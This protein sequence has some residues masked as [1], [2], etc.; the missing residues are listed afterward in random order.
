MTMQPRTLARFATTGIAVVALLVSSAVAMATTRG[1]TT[2]GA[3]HVESS[4]TIPHANASDPLVTAEA[5]NGVV[6]VAVPRNTMTDDIEIAAGAHQP[7][8]FAIVPSGT[9]AM[10]FSKTDL[11]VAGRHAMSSFSRATGAVIRT[12]EVRVAKTEGAALGYGDGRLWALG[13]NG[14]GRHVFEIKPG[15]AGQTVVGSGHNV[16]SIA[17]G[18]RGVYF[19]R[20]G[21]HRLVRVAAD[22]TH[23]TAPTHETVN[24]ELSGPAAVQATAVDGGTLLVVHDAGQGFDAV[25]VRYNAKSLKH[26]SSAPTDDTHADAVPTTAGDLVL[27]A[28]EDSFG[29]SNA[30]AKACVARISTK[31]AKVSSKVRLPRGVAL[32]G[33]VGPDPAVVIG[34]HG[35][36]HLIRLT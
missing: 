23:V 6:A 1:S 30:S 35:H 34:R 2:P 14:H 8:V 5:S 15:S 28:H 24:E 4:A 19:V 36:A 7:K 29:C 16:A 33:L 10:A 9:A 20:S 25:L 13:S 17:A 12:W 11:F 31:T 21:G 27:I 26:L 22:G 18:P 3:L 32:S